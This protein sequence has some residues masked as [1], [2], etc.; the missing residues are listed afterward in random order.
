MNTSIISDKEK[1]WATILHLSAFGQF[2]FPFFGCIWIP[3]IIWLIKREK[4][5]FI[6]SQ[7]KEVINFNLTIVLAWIMSIILL[8]VGI[9]IFFGTASMDL[10]NNFDFCISP[11]CIFFKILAL[12][13]VISWFFGI[14]IF[15]FI[16][17]IVGAI[18]ANDGQAYGYPLRIRFLR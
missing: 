8:I 10:G 2:I 11:L 6:D 15:W 5:S 18:K 12:I 16:C 9:G 4:E 7:G 1:N 17:T 3:L 14:L 13:G